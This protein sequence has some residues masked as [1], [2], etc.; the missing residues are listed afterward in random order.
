MFRF[1]GQQ[2]GGGGGGQPSGNAPSQGDLYNQADDDDDL[3]S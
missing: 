2:Q 3:Y 1:P